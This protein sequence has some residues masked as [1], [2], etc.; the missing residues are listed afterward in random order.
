MSLD[1][2]EQV[3]AD[4]SEITAEDVEGLR[5]LG[6][7]DVEALDVAL[8]AAAGCFFARCSMAREPCLIPNSATC[9]SHHLG[10]FSLL[11]S[12]SSSTD[13]LQSKKPVS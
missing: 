6:L 11:G 10:L 8:A 12:G 9:S 3:A 4:A 5:R 13:S 2:A 1:F 7:S